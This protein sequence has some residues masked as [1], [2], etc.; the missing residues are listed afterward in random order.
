SF[1][2]RLYN[3]VARCCDKRDRQGRLSRLLERIRGN[4]HEFRNE[5]ATLVNAAARFGFDART[6][7]DYLARPS[8]AQFCK[9][10]AEGRQMVDRAEIEERVNAARRAPLAER[11]A[12]NAPVAKRPL[13]MAAAPG[14]RPP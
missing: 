12:A 2:A 10:L 1:R 13:R 7:S 4:E 6:F 5:I 8:D 9:L 3:L 14:C 11:P